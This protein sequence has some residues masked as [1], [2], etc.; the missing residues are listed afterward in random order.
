[1][2]VELHV[3]DLGIV[4]DLN[5]VLGAGPDRDHRRDRRGQDAARRGARAA[6]RRPRRRRR[7]C[8]TAPPRRGSRAVRAPETGEETVLAPRRA[9]RRPQPRVRRRPPRDRG[10]ARRGRRA[11]S[12]TCTGSTRT[13][14]CSIP[15]MQRGALDRYAGRA[16]ARRA[17]RATAP[18][19]PRSATLD[20]ELA[21]LGG[22]D[23]ARAREIDLLR[24]QVDEIDAAALDDPTEDDALEA[25]EALLAD[26]DAHRDA[27]DRAR[28]RRSRAPALDALGAAVAALAGRGAVRRRSP[29]ALRGAQAELAELAHELR[30]AVGAGRRRP[31]AARR[32]CA[33]PPPPAP[34]ARAASTATLADVIAYGA[35]AAR[36]PRRARALRGA[37]RRAR[38]RAAPR[39][40][41]EAAAAAADARRRPGA[42][43]P[44]R[45]ATAVTGHLRELAMPH[46]DGRDRGRA[47]AAPP[48]TA[49]TTSPSSWPPTRASPP[50]RWPGPRPAASSPVRCWRCASCS[51]RRRRRSCST[52]ST[53]GSAARPGP[54]SA[55][56]C[57]ARAR[58]TRCCASPTS[59]RSP[60]S[61]TRRSWSR[62][63]WNG[64]A[65]QERTVAR[66]TVVDGDDAG[67][68]AV[69][70]AR[71][72]RRLGPR[73]AATPTSCWRPPAA[74]P[75]TAR[76]RADG[77]GTPLMARLRLRK[78]SDAPFD[79]PGH[80]RGSTGAPRTSSSG[81]RRARSRSS[82]TTTSTASRPTALIEA[83]VV[84]VVNAR[85]RS[86]AATRTAGRSGSC[87]PASRSST[88]S[89]PTS[90]TRSARA[91]SSASSDGEVWRDGELLATRH[92]ARR[93]RDRGGDGGR[94]RDDRH[95][96]RALRREHARVHPQGGAAHVRAARRSRRCTRSSRAGTRSSSCAATTT[97]TTS[98]RCARTSASTS[99]CSSA[100]TA[101]PTRCSSTASSPT[102]SS[103]TS[104][105]CRPS[106][107]R[108]RRRARAPRAPRRPR[109]GRENLLEWG[110][111][112]HEFVAEGTSE[113]VAMLLAYE[114][115]AAHRRGRHPRDDGRV[116]RQGPPGH[117][118]DVPHPAAPRPGARRR[119]GR[120]PALRGPRP[121]PATSCCS[122]APRSIAMLVVGHRRRTHPRV[123]ARPLGHPQGLSSRADDQLPVPPRLAR[124]RSSSP[125]RSGS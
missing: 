97:A 95:R 34:R 41:R 107:L 112:Y 42:P 88:T 96:A 108:V 20:A 53:P 50:G 62:R 75:P 43:P 82:T 114:R 110:V 66:A 83:G 120:E 35:E 122:S 33:A 60:R 1:M 103:A 113:D 38:G 61:P 32:R 17:R 24:Y 80:R 104:T 21:A 92:G 118:V 77:R 85:R 46:A 48:T 9:A 123:R 14:R 125:S 30:R 59:R 7:S 19:A 119:Q 116:P 81:C 64:S 5:L 117:G 79:D 31:G 40:E 91:T 106:G 70:H 22:D 84:A 8:A 121:P 18:H 45:S 115:G 39:H 6:R 93:G 98:P 49:P 27:L 28:T 44:S 67:R 124:S 76:R 3:D 54:R 25:E 71:R 29:T 105:R 87:R 72:G 47:G 73:P 69:A 10:R 26:A 51:R 100:S 4:A 55:A 65:G 89:A 13:S 74:A 68:R 2:L 58:G 86:P 90:W 37:R 99:R 36:P 12:S 56:R 109:P 23:R 78:Q 57:G 101:A 102:S 15:P 16:R 111:E 11:R 63:P 94:A 52:R